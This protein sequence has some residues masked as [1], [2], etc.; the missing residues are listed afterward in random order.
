MLVAL[1]W[2]VAAAIGLSVVYGLYGCANGY[3]HLSDAEASFYAGVHR[4]AWAIAV[5]WVIFACV[6][7]NGGWW[8]FVGVLSVLSAV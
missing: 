6:T 3:V 5:G 8:C 4:T 2:L 1:F 7:G